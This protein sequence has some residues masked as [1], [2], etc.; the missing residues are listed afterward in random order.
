[1]KPIREYH[2]ESYWAAR[3]EKKKKRAKLKENIGTVILTI[4][5]FLLEGAIT[6]EFLRQLFE[7]I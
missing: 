1:M 7:V 5:L 2:I 3:A 4:V 6:C